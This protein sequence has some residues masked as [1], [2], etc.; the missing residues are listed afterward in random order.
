[1]CGI[2]GWRS[3]N[4]QTSDIS[5][6]KKK[7]IHR[8]PDSQGIFTDSNIVL[9]HNRLSIID[10]SDLANQPM[11]D[12]S[13]N[14][15]LVFNGEIY[16]Y[17]E[18]R[19]ELTNLGYNF[20]TN[21]DTEVVLNSY[22]E[23]NYKC[24]NKF[25]GMFAFVIYNKVDNLFFLA[26][27]RFGIKPLLFYLKNNDFIFSSELTPF[28][29]INFISKDLNLNS[30]H[31]LFKFGNIK[32]PDTIINE[33][34]FLMP[35]CYMIV[36]KTNIQ[37]TYS[38][39]TLNS[40]I[41]VDKKYSYD[42]YCEM[43]R[44]RLEE[45]TKLHMISDFEVGAY[46]S[47]GIDSTI[48]T[49]LMQNQ[50]STQIKTFCLGFEKNELSFN[51]E[52]EVATI[53]S[54]ILNTNHTNIHISNSYVLNCFDDFINHIDQPSSD[55][56]NT[57]F[58]SKESS[59]SVKVALSGLGG[60]EIFNGY[61]LYDKIYKYYNYKL[62]LFSKIGLIIEKIISNRYTR[63]YLLYEN[64][65]EQ[66][67]QLLRSNKMVDNYF[68]NKIVQESQFNIDTTLN[69]SQKIMKSE[70]EGYLINTLLRDCDIFSMS[71]SQEVRPVLLDHELVNFSFNIPTEF[72]IN[73][74]SNKK[75]LIDSVYDLIPKNVLNKK[76]IGFNM[77]YVNWMNG[78]LNK[79]FIRV[80]D[81]V[82]YNSIFTKNFF[83]LLKLRVKNKKTVNMDWTV[84][85]F[86]EWVRKHRINI[87]S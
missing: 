84:F 11:I 12:D 74:F 60:D 44:I 69:V 32:Q 21:S 35:G 6:F 58:V 65:P 55:G 72:K 36:S 28:L 63:D 45:V 66:A 87:Y 14:Y 49:S 71:N 52:T 53:T 56:I 30:V 23:W 2:Y 22:L 13:G 39:Y 85:I 46:L 34:S 51:D 4:L 29:D 78:I 68:K 40:H 26:R 73:N 83:N 37:T 76:K 42:E 59:K 5:N 75:I 38:Y 17:N 7:L 86:L 9:G 50:S 41:L 33:I 82:Q 25:R 57:F 1:M 19:A 27:D 80:L 62:N 3:N 18:I 64:T 81:E 43:L 77:P 61:P 10:N 15:I 48:V 24:L 8:G 54:K 31:N 67:L 47:G 16:N 20:K 79:K 70:I